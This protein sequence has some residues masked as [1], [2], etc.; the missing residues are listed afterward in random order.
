MSNG[1]TNVDHGYT[2]RMIVVNETGEQLKEGDYTKIPTVREYLEKN[3]FTEFKAQVING[4]ELARRA[5]IKAL[6]EKRNRKGNKEGNKEDI[7]H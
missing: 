6:M 5:R 4:D 3:P 7:I 2:T 1:T